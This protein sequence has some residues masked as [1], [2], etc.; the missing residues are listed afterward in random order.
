MCY[1]HPH[2]SGRASCS[3]PFAMGMCLCDI[4]KPYGTIRLASKVRFRRAL[5]LGGAPMG[6]PA[7]NPAAQCWRLAKCQLQCQVVDS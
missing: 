3:S 2:S 1:S 5:Y 4:V 6:R 7:L